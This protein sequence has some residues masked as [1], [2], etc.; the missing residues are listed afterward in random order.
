VSEQEYVPFWRKLCGWL[1][2]SAA[3]LG[4]AV[5]LSLG[6]NVLSTWLMTAPGS[7]PSNTPWSKIMAQWPIVL[8][9]GCCLLLLSLLARVM[10]RWPTYTRFS[11]SRAQQSREHMLELLRANYQTLTEKDAWLKLE[12]AQRP[13][14]VQNASTWLFRRPHQADQLFPPGTSI[15][16]AYD[17]AGHELLIL[18]EPGAGKST[19]LRDLARQL[20]ERAKADA[21][22]PLPILLP[23]SSWAIKR[24]SLQ[25]WLSEQLTQLYHISR[26]LSE[27]WVQEG[28]IL[29]LLDGFDEMDEA[30]RPACI[31]ALKT[32]HRNHPMPLVVCSRTVEYEVA[33]RHQRLTLQGAVIVQ[34]LSSAQVDAYLTRAGIKLAALRQALKKNPALQ[35]LAKT[36]LMLNVLMSTCYGMPVQRFSKK[37]EALQQE[38]WTAYVKHMF[39][40]RGNARQY[41]LTR[42]YLWLGWLAQQM[43]A[44]NQTVFY[45][46]H[47]QPD[48]LP[49]KHRFFYQCSVVFVVG[50]LV[51]LFDVLAWMLVFGLPAFLTRILS[52][53]PLNN[54]VEGSLGGLLGA[55]PA[56]LVEGLVIGLFIGRRAIEP[57]EKLTWSWN[58]IRF[59][60]FVGV[61][62]ALS[63]GAILLFFRKLGTRI[64]GKQLAERLYLS[65]NEGMRRSAKN[66]LLIGLLG[67]PIGGLFV[68]LLAGLLA[69]SAIKPVFG[70]LEWLFGGLS[71]GLVIGLASG[72][73]ACI[74][75]Y[76]LRF[77]LARCGVFPWRAIPFLED[78]TACVLL[79][80]VDGG[81]SFAHR[82]LLDFFADSRTGASSA[83]LAPQGTPRLPP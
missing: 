30:A 40:L 27:Q 59:R 13:D 31:A 34:P 12:L 28:Q 43:R 51:V 4:T 69:P 41:P 58:E 62:I 8:L 18:G 39:E 64:T 47:I 25:D 46:E 48:W 66:G 71:I 37:K 80:R 81:Y 79:Q 19:L 54:Y 6:V 32:Y 78:A 49:S 14:A 38:V 23:L 56:G 72:L 7:I 20:V 61:S 29:P 52:G 16:H 9:V 11:S 10:S 3:F 60:L 75:H 33:A 5:F 53:L 68:G 63:G 22:H 74:Q 57:S 21:A 42:L 70:L 82:L 55:L 2:K 73:G 50:L 83:S 67:V 1:W 44:H 17:E 45:L 26:Q 24:L 77:W 35:E 15:I 65:P 76:T 36:P